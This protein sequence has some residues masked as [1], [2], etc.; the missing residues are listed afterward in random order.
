MIEKWSA[1]VFNRRWV[2]HLLGGRA[3]RLLAVSLC[4]SCALATVMQGAHAQPAPALAARAAVDSSSVSQSDAALAEAETAYRE[5]RDRDAFAKFAYVLATLP[6]E[7]HAWLRIGNLWQRNGESWRAAEAYRRAVEA[8]PLSRDGTEPQ[9]SDA[10][11]VPRAGS[12]AATNLAILGIEQAQTAMQSVDRSRL[13]AEMQ[14]TVESIER[15]L[16]APGVPVREPA[17][18]VLR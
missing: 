18:P 12:K 13:P 9:R 3:R 16:R 7:A 17:R 5:Q 15:S 4:S 2:R 8:V 6:R 1:V 11:A 10:E 14:P